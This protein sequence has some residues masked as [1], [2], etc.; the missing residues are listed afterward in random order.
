MED[1][2]GGWEQW[3]DEPDRQVFVYRPDVFDSQAFPAPCLP[4]LYLS[5]GPHRN[6][7]PEQRH[8]R[9]GCSWHLTLYLEPDVVLAEERYDERTEASEAATD[10]ARRFADG[11]LDYRDA[12]QVP[13]EAYLDRLDE[14]TGR[15]A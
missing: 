2:P 4:T 15:E 7:R 6:R 1:P 3:S 8:E 9:G 10:L 11:D 13:R 5:N 14:L 12:Y